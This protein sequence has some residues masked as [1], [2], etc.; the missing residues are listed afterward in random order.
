MG[1]IGIDRRDYL[2]HLRW[3]EIMCIVKGYHRRARPMWEAARLVAYSAA[4][5]MGGKN[6]PPMDKWLEFGWE[7]KTDHQELS[8]EDTE[9]LLEQ[10]RAFNT[11]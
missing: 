6:I 3:W 11:K 1:E 7:K 5:C 4:H 8:Q 9:R 10:M 2:F